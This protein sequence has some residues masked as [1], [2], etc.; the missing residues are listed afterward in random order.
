[1]SDD[2]Y[3]DV[4]KSALE[5]L[6]SDP[7]RAREQAEPLKVELPPLVPRTAIAISDSVAVFRRDRFT[8]QYCGSAVVPT[9]VLRAASLLWP[10]LIPYNANWRGDVTHPIYIA[11]SATVDH[12]VPH[13][14]G[15]LDEIENFR[16]ACWPCNTQKSDLTIERLGWT[17]LDV[18]ETGWDGLVGVYSTLWAAAEENA[19]GSDSRFHTRWLAEFN[20]D[21]A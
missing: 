14:H 6:A 18:P 10:D 21:D 19:T 16:T 17:V 11:R 2:R 13:A 20:K 3:L 9:C 12:L 1:M 8:C 15:G 5:S 4:L 7:E